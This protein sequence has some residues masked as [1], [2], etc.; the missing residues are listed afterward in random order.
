MYDIHIS[1]REVCIGLRPRD[2]ITPLDA[3]VTSQ[4]SWLLLNSCSGFQSLPILVL[5]VP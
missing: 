3:I 4:L 5:L 1:P 2:A